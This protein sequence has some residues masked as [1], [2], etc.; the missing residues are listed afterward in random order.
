MT[1]KKLLLIVS[2]VII[3]MFSMMLATSYAWYSFENGRTTFSAV[4]NDDVIEVSYQSGEYISTNIAVPIT[5][6]QIDKYS[7]KSNFN[8]KVKNNV[9]SNEVMVA[10]KL[11]DVVIANE[12]KNNSFIV[13]LY[14]RGE[15][16]KTIAGTNITNGVDLSLSNVVLEDDLSN[17]FEIR[18]KVRRFI[19]KLF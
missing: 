3:S 14:Y 18:V 12:L 6:K 10:V 2:I 15:L 9:N 1:L 5:E 11:V 17:Q 19:E 8:I 13:D 4:T 7:D 16:L